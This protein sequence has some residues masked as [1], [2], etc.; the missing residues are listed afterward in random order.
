MAE[1]DFSHNVPGIPEGAPLPEPVKRSVGAEV[2]QTPDYQSAYSNYAANTN[3][4]SSI[5]SA[6]A[7]RAS[8]AIA[9]QLG[10]ELGKNPQGTIPEFTDFDKAMNDS[11]TT[12]AASTLGLQA[13]KLITDSN[14]EMSKAP[15]IT[16]ELIAKTNKSVSLGLQNIFANAPI[17]VK[18]QLEL[19][20]KQ[21]QM[22]QASE[23]A[24]RMVRQNKEDRINNLDLSAKTNSE[25]LYSLQL[26]SNDLDKN[27]DSKS[28]LATEAAL[29][30]TLD[31]AVAIG[32]KTP[33]ERKVA[34]DSAR[35][36]RLSAK[37][38]RVGL[39][40]QDNR[41][42]PEFRKNLAEKPPADVSAED[43]AAVYQNVI[44]YLNNQD[45]LK[46]SDENLKS[47]LMYNRIISAPNDISGTEWASFEQSVSPEK[48]AEMKFHLIQAQ[49]KKQTTEAGVNELMKNY[50]DPRIQANASPEVKNAAF[51]KAV[52]Y[53]I[54]Q[55]PN[56]SRDEAEVQ[57]AMTAGE[58]APVFTKTMQNKLWSGDPAQMISAA[59][60][61]DA[62]QLSGNGHALQNLN[63]TDK[64]IASD[65]AHNYNSADPAW[66]ARVVTENRQNQDPTVRKQ[67]EISWSSYVYD[68]TI[69]KGISEDDFILG[70]FGLNSSWDILGLK[71][72]NQFDSPWAKGNYAADI[73][74][75]YRT[76][77]IN[78]RGDQAR[79]QALTQQYVSQNYGRTNINGQEEFTKHPIEKAI[80][81]SQGQGI[82]A[83]N[84]D[85]IRQTA[86]P[87]SKLRE[88]YNNKISDTFWSIE[89]ND[90]TGR[91]DF[92]KY[93][94]NGNTTD[95]VKFPLR[96]VGNNFN[97]ELNVDTATGPMSVFLAA[98]AIGVHQYT[99]DSNWIRK[100]ATI[101]A[102]M[103][104]VHPSY[105][106][107]G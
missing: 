107:R 93:T 1:L 32:D 31:A 105:I 40:A 35:Q 17:Q 100:Q 94:R 80:G 51:N 74:D 77:F 83:I 47:Q 67:T 71:V 82:D 68:N 73:M 5:G 98:P 16:P 99:P 104:K 102:Q 86:V 52:D 18:P 26:S 22:N 6:V 34:L 92:V 9:T 60:Q 41:T 44:A 24:D 42:E 90:K 91:L 30:K 2:I 84:R 66:A 38:I 19:Q 54:N 33:L 8:N 50:S 11:Y 55:N 4:M 56:M 27:G 36:S 14:V 76:N 89:K 3:W 25:A 79:S 101:D 97:W 7:G 81:L 65:I 88:A 21:Q 39:E 20:Y 58:P 96:L 28:A 59:R 48:A 72:G 49:N 95:T 37:Y 70:Q 75:V 46:S 85:I 29:K 87:M 57:V 103:K 43:H 78:T 45:S 64:A 62:L 13:H 12:Q 69:K 10:G 23:L 53:T 15:R 63:D 106:G 61:V